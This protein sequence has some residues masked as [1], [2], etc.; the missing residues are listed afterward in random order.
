MDALWLIVLT[1]GALI[2]LK[3]RVLGLVVCLA[4]AFLTLGDPFLSMI[5]VIA[6]L[7]VASLCLLKWR[8]PIALPIL[9]LIA[10]IEALRSSDIAV[11][12]VCFIASSVPT[13]ALIILS[14][15][16]KPRTAVKYVTFMV[17]ATVLFIFGLLNLNDVVGKVAFIIGLSL[18]IG[19]APFH[20]WVPDVFEEGDPV[21]VSIIASLAKFVPVLIAFR[22][23]SPDI[24]TI[25]FLFALSTVSM[26]IGNVGALTSGK[27]ERILS[28]STIANMGYVT[29][30]LA[31]FNP[32]GFAGAFIQ[33]LAN[34]FAKI[35]FFTA[36][37][38]G[39]SRIQTYIL[40][41]SMIG[42]PPLL[43]F[44]GKFFIIT[45]LVKSNL[46]LLALILVV[47]S[48][49]SVPY[50]VRL[51]GMYEKGRSYLVLSIV[52]A[53]V[54]MSLMFYPTPIYEGVIS[55]MR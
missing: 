45:S 19:V 11:L 34:S 2:S 33:L 35:G 47:N 20:I 30:A 31:S 44:W 15:D 37:K 41:F 39:A 38:D 9:M 8:T 48:V 23:L 13:Y 26:F 51:A 4:L 36:L 18:E 32:V 29:S 46:V 5:T 3:N 10:T 1:I 40:S 43:G 21:T 52:T 16:L 55:W 25:S 50:Y 49:I 53:C 14:D 24:V 17:M 6:V 54:I 12:I 7:N 27:A 42:V 22:V 28:Y